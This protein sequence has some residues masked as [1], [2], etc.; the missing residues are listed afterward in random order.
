LAVALRG[1]GNSNVDQLKVCRPAAAAPR[2]K[3]SGRRSQPERSF[4]GLVHALT[5]VDKAATVPR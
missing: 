2:M 1:G 3:K 4:D 5:T